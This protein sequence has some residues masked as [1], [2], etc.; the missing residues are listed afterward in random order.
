M[1]DGVLAQDGF[2]L[3]LQQPD[4]ALELGVLAGMRVDLPGPEQL[5]ADGQ[6]GLAEVLVA[7]AAF[8]KKLKVALEM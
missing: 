4:A 7:A 6:A 2:E 3:A 1:L 8:G 5:L